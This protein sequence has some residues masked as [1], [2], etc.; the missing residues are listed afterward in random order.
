MAN[1]EDIKGNSN[2]LRGTIVEEL[3]NGEDN[4]SKDAYQ[5][6]KF[7]GTYQQDDRDLR[8]ERRKQKLGRAYIMMVRS[9]IPGGFYTA[10]QYLAH[11][12][13]A[14]DLANGSIRITSRQGFQLHGVVKGDLESVI[15]MINECG[16]TTWGA[17]GDV[18]R[19]VMA[20]PWPIDDAAHRDIKKLSVEL[21][22][23]FAAKSSAYSDI[24]LD[25]E[26]ITPDEEEDEPIY[27][28]YYLPRKFKFGIAIPPR[29]DVDIFTNDV[30]LAAIVDETGEV[31]GYN[32]YAGGG[33]G[34]T[35]GKQETHPSLAKPLF[36]APR[37]KV[38]DACTAIVL[39]QRDHGE[40]VNRK[41]AR[42]KY[43]IR[44]RGMEWF[45]SEV[46]KRM[47][48]TE[49]LEDVKDVKWTTVSDL[50]GWHEQGDG[51]WFHCVWVPEGRIKDYEEGKYKSAFREIAQTYG[52]PMRNTA[53]CN[54]LLHDI[55]PEQREAINKILS[56]HGIAATEEMTEARKVCQACVALP[57]CG[58][59]LGESERVFGGVMDEIDQ[60]LRELH[61]EKEPL[62]VR[63]T[64]C[65][66]GCARPYNADIAFVG[67]GPGRYAFYVGGS[68][69]GERLGGLEKH[70]IQLDEIGSAVRPY[71][72]EFAHNRQNGES[73]SEYW[74]R[75]HQNG[76]EPSSAQ[77]HEELEK[78][79]LEKM[80][81]AA[82]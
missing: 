48:S 50:L 16:L 51:K 24:W 15:R 39:V 80:N 69:T 20:S 56:K 78:Q 9:K 81:A 75:T 27:G 14:D 26:K 42:M 40:R 65:P 44:D 41:Q 43:L 25:G 64:G 77:F 31:K 53:N 45:K 23:Q 5:L 4:F 73:F 32:I 70:T 34:M 62:L 59:A 60:I 49:G 10:E 76:E 74:G 47:Q 12:K 54:V 57:T 55:A 29:N 82:E 61:L 38:V 30:G 2:S 21:K 1:L 35:H 11:D 68:S 8:Q 66:N 17:C 72:E 71:L 58:L 36:Y 28:K 33:F 63:M 13:A 7:H 37:D 18:V 67:R 52:L 6:L 79:Q 3:K 46:L 19:N 22:D